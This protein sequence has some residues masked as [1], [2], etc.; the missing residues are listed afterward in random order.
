MT[1]VT[2]ELKHFGPYRVIGMSCTDQK[3]G[4]LWGG[5]KGFLARKGE[6]KSP[7]DDGML[8]GMSRCLP[9][10]SQEYIAAITVTADSSVPDGMVEA[11]IGDST[12][13]VITV[14]GMSQIGQGWSA[15]HAWLG[16]NGEWHSYCVRDE[17][18]VCGCQDYPCFEL[19][20][21]DHAKT[22][23]VYIYVPVRCRT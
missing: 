23:L 6:I 5:E 20:P 17:N 13:A 16:S 12:Y 2:P 1:D 8:F 19:Y 7:T 3:Y 21:A 14:K 22:D 15:V 4:E 10:N 18:G 9:D 11:V